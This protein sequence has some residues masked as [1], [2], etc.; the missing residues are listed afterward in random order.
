MRD[1]WGEISAPRF[2]KD[3]DMKEM[4]DLLTMKNGH[5]INDEFI[6]NKI[7]ERKKKDV[8]KQGLVALQSENYEPHP[9]TLMNYSLVLARNANTSIYKT[10]IT[11]L[12]GRYTAENSLVSAMAL[13]C[14]IAATHFVVVPEK[15]ID[16]YQE[17]DD[18]SK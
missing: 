5:S 15:L 7:K 17:V 3:K 2:L 4:N 9:R 11:K 1:T 10:V 8:E 12:S 13:L 18:Y 16:I 6:L 14:V